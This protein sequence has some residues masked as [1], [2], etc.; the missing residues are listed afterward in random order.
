M[1]SD[2]GKAPVHSG[3]SPRMAKYRRAERDWA[4]ADQQQREQMPRDR[5]APMTVRCPVKGCDS[6]VVSIERYHVTVEWELRDV[7]WDLSTYDSGTHFHLFCD[8]GH[9]SKAWG[10]QL[11]ERLQSVVYPG[12]DR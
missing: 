12:E 8:T 11:A 7:G 1:S 2:S 9:E 3:H 10:S 4:E 6:L 5:L